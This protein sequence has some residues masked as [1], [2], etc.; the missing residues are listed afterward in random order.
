MNSIITFVFFVIWLWQVS[1]NFTI[2]KSSNDDSNDTDFHILPYGTP[3]AFPSIF[4]NGTIYPKPKPPPE[5]VHS[6]EVPTLDDDHFFEPIKPKPKPKPPTI[7]SDTAPIIY[8]DIIEKKIFPKDSESFQ[9]FGSH[10]NVYNDMLV[11]GTNFL[12]IE[13]SVYLFCNNDDT[14]IQNSK[15]YTTLD[16][17]SLYDGFGLSFAID[18]GHF[19]IGA[20]YDNSVAVASGIVYVYKSTLNQNTQCLEKKEITMSDFYTIQ[21]QSALYS[22]SH[23]GKSISI[24]NNI[25]VIGAPGISA[26][27]TQSGEAFV[28]VFDEITQS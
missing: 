17:T 18:S 9:R 2:P 8:A 22:R 15:L 20:M 13:S 1:G 27:Y 16:S 7:P 23:F 12:G 14:W 5:I 10:V 6:S 28:F 4:L 21:P 25:A 26:P 3:S 24:S 11:V 19:M